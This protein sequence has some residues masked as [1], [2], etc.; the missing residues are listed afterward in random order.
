MDSS[1]GFVTIL[2]A[3]ELERHLRNHL[4]KLNK[5]RR[6]SKK[7]MWRFNEFVGNVITAKLKREEKQTQDLIQR[8]NP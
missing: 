2:I 7:R 1:I 6:R 3:P 4:R 5:K 8:K